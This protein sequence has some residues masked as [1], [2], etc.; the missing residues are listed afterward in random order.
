MPATKQPKP[1]RTEIVIVGGGLAGMTLA[2]LLGTAGVDC[3]CLDRLGMPAMTDKTYDGRTTAISLASRR[4]LEAAGVWDLVLDRGQAEPIKDIRI[5]DDF[6]PLFLH[7]D[8]QDVGDEPFGHIVDNRDLRLAMISRI[9]ALPSVRLEAPMAVTKTE[10][11]GGKVEVHLEDGR[12][13]EAALLVGADGRQSPTRQAAGI[14]IDHWKYNQTAI[15]CNVTHSKPHNNLALE[16]F[17][18]AGPFAVLP[19]TDAADGRSRSS[20]VWTEAPSKAASM[21]E[22]GEEHFNQELQNRFGEYL[23]EVAVEGRRFT[24]PLSVLHARSYIAPRTA[25]VAEAAHAIHPIAGQGLNLG[26]RDVAALAELVVDKKRLGLDI[27][28]TDVLTRYQRWRRR[29]NVTLMVVTDGLNR[30]FSNRVGPVRR[31]R[32][33]GLAAVE[34][35][36]PAKRFFMRHAMGSVGSL[37]RIVRGEAL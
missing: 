24:Y 14:G 30:L 1:E 21:V 36:P 13:I 19:M 33:L 7:F 11:R 4:V 26:M 23:G 15:V 22:L 5:A 2:S 12:V 25:L 9:E 10:Q 6:A 18:P 8:S 34:R 16:H 35:L 17:M 28:S 3:V 32:Q 27:G 20:V 37:P 29:D 31:L